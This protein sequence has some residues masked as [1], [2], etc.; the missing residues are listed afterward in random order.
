MD[1]IEAP[2]I[3]EHHQKQL[4]FTP[5]DVKWMPGSA[6]CALV[7]QTPKMKGVVKFHQL[8]REELKEIYSLEDV[9]SGFKSCAF[10]YHGTSNAPALFLADITG[11]LFVFD[12]EAQRISHETQAHRSMVNTLDVAGGLHTP[13]PNEVVTGSR[14]GTVKLWDLRQKEPVLV[15]EP[16]DKGDT[17]PDCWAVALG[18][19]HSGE[20]RAIA[21]GYDNGDVKLFDLRANSLIWDHNLKNGVC[22]LQFDR[23]DINMNKLG[24][25]TLEGKVHIF[26]LRTKH[27]VHGYAGLVQG[28]TNA[29]VWG[30][31]H[32]PQNRDLFG[33]LH[34]DGYLR[35]YKYKYPTQRVIE[36]ADGHKKGVAGS[37]EL[38][39]DRQIAQQPIVGFDWSMD[40]IGLG[41]SCALDQTLKIIIVTKLN[42][43]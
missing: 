14:D 38:L 2:Q 17:P 18:N 30:L 9:G 31:R 11:R 16:A 5:F 28:G 35:L 42:L 25:T 6:K 20:D 7:G 15:L 40:K 12:V 13:G 24:V 32:L 21:S 41:V 29:T 37:L 4:N 26:D 22:G 1:T 33:S 10:N 36:D 39:N 34:G 3:F 19:S 8:E 27:P 43:Y 23:K